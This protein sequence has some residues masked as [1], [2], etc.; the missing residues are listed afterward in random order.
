MLH[1]IRCNIKM[2]NFVSQ[3]ERGNLVENRGEIF[4]LDSTAFAI[5]DRCRDKSGRS[6]DTVDVA[7]H[8]QPRQPGISFTLV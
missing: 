3:R 1:L 8:C 5:F 6:G 4:K 2:K 7:R